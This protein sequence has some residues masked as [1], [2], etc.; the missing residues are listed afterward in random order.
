MQIANDTITF[1]PHYGAGPRTATQDVT[2]PNRITT[3]VAMLTG[4]SVEY[5]H[6]DDHHLGNLQVGVARHCRRQRLRGHEGVACTSASTFVLG[7][8]ALIKSDPK[9]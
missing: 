7:E 2:V 4:M 3:A 6:G 8:D 1:S 5:S 9:G